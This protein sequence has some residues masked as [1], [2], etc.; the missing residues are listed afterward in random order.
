M[1]TIPLN[2]N[3][4]AVQKVYTEQ[5]VSLRIRA[6]KDAGKSLRQIATE[7]GKPILHSDI[8]RILDGVFPVGVAKREALHIPP[9]CVTC[10]QR[11]KYVRHIP[12]WLVEATDNLVALETAA[13]PSPE[14]IRVY[15]RGGK[16]VRV[17][18]LSLNNYKS[19]YV[20]VCESGYPNMETAI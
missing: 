11:V 19:M 13:I 14:P 15:A 9:I 7:Y 8:E 12:A 4:K 10:G 5:D 3:K 20:C 17:N 2:R 16:R 18:K 1:S 6:Q